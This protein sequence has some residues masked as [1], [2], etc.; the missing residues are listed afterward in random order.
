MNLQHVEHFFSHD[1]WI[2]DVTQ[3]PKWQR[4]GVSALRLLS[5]V[6]WEFRRRLLDARAAGLVY[7]TLLSLVPFLA[8][9]VSV[10]KAFG[11]HQQIEPLLSQALEPLG[12]SGQEITSRVVGFVSNL[13]VG[14]LGIV[15]VAGL[16]YTTY[17]LIDKIEQ[18]FNA[19]WNVR[20][21][22]SLTRKFADY[23]SVVLVGPVLIVT[24]FGLL[25]S[26]QNHALVQRILDLQPLGFIFVW[27]A[28]YLPFLILWSVFTFFYKFIPHTEVRVWSACV[29]GATAA[30]LW[31][32]AGEGFAAFVAD[33]SKYSVIYSSFAI[34]ILFLLWLY[35]GWLI[36][37]I[38]A[39]V[40]YFHQHPHAY[41]LHFLWR[42]GTH[43]FRE[44]TALRLLASMATR[45]IGGK[46]P[47]TLDDLA[48]DAGVPLSIIDDLID[49]LRSSGLVERLEDS[50]ALVLLR[51]PEL[52][53][54]QTVLDILR[55]KSAGMSKVSTSGD[56]IDDVIRC[57]DDA[58]AR[59]L[60]G[61]T[62]RN[63]AD[64]TPP[65]ESVPASSSGIE[66]SLI[67][68]H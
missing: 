7:T 46:P 19:I 17:S 62:L 48:A 57:R 21:G 9:T 37:L 14:V 31:G 49:E 67:R 64:Q 13:K 27:I 54:I 68:E 38:G 18:T 28:E 11:V 60:S 35:V 30:L 39:Q 41:E 26:I 43:A 3:L 16:F 36:I 52:I 47:A 44:R 61:L 45:T 34:M 8:V 51:P 58:A 42:Q 20:H 53:G 32:V 10:L 33:S 24:A 23:L 22:R 15:G 6:T 1:L 25:A 5:A 65:S 29:G 59:A 50:K 12:P 56:A 2:L 4:I 40:A 55:E 63:L 66:R